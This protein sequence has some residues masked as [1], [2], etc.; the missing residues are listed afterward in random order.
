VTGL[1]PDRSRPLRAHDAASLSPAGRLVDL[2]HPLR[3]GMPT[4]PGLPAPRIEP[5]I[6]HAASRGTY[7]GHAEFEITRLFLAGNSGTYLDSPYHRDPGAPDL[8]ELPLEVTTALPGLCVDGRP[9]TDQRALEIE[10]A[11]AEL[12]GHAVLVRTGW[13]ARWGRAAYWE[14]GPYLAGSLVD[15][16]VAAGAVL[17]G[18]DAWNVDDP[19]DPVRPAHTRL[20]RAGIPIVEHLTGLGGLPRTGFRFTAAPIAI[21]GAA[22]IP[23]RAY[24]ELPG[25]ASGRRSPRS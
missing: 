17:V 14:P 11:D 13:D 5:L 10:V 19:R 9:T 16:L 24:A 20:L 21:H 2:S 3:S 15:R 6:S 23:V 4:Y 25:T 22:S 12:R 18:I 1:R 7:G 8:A